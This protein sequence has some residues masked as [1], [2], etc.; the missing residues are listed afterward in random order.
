MNRT[1]HDQLVQFLCDYSV[2]QQALGIGRKSVGHK[3]AIMNLGRKGFLLFAR[4]LPETPGKLAAHAKSKKLPKMNHRYLFAAAGY[5]CVFLATASAAEP[6]AVPTLEEV[7]S[8]P[9]QQVTGV[10]VSKEGR[11]FVNFPFWSDEHTTSVA[12]VLPGGD[13][14]PYPDAVWNSPDGPPQKRWVCVQSVVVDSNND[15]WVLDPAS[16]KTEAVVPDGP[17]LVRFDLQ[18]NQVIQSIGFDGSVAPE[19]SYLNDVRFDLAGGYAFITESGVGSIVVVDLKT[20]QARRR[21]AEHT[22]TKK[23]VNAQVTVDGF[24]VVDPK[25]G[26]APNF[27]ADGIALDLQNGWLYYHPLA[28]E[29]LYRV[30]TKDLTDASLSEQALGE[31]VESLGAT[32]K[33]D[34]MLEGS[35]GSVFLTAIEED[36]IVLFDPTSRTT[37]LVVRDERLQWPDTM[38]WGP[39]KYLYVTASQI[40]RM[41]KYNGGANEQAGPYRLFRFKMQ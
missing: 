14:R 32:P 29:T 21:L 11:V 20:G 28:G 15:L 10:A 40:H 38:A 8:F 1:P 17:K 36:G 26:T 2:E 41:P 34:G 13:I 5:A 9:T 3:N 4:L 23:E 24:R 31:K 12:E 35:G 37:T 30:R 7:A 33:P 19:R 25:T 6:T 18:K 39:D 22:S 27:N 16:P